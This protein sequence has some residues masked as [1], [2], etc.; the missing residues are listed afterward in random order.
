MHSWFNHSSFRQLLYFFVRSKPSIQD[1]S[2]FVFIVRDG[3]HLYESQL[4]DLLYIADKQKYGKI[5]K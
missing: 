1:F 2:F 3:P 5:F 4:T